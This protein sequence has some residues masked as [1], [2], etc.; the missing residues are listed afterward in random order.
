MIKELIKLHERKY[1]HG[2]V[3]GSNIIF[4]DTSVLIDFDYAGPVE[5]SV[6]PASYAYE[7]LGDVERHP[8]ARPDQPM[9][10][11]HDIAAL[12]PQR[13]VRLSRGPRQDWQ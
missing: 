6:Y 11:A 12:L 9:K 5:G 2:D 4:G 10:Q 3:R 8:E 7:N 1:C 13:T